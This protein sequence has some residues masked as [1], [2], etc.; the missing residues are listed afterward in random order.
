MGIPQQSSLKLEFVNQL[1]SSM[2]FE[3]MVNIPFLFWG[4]FDRNLIYY[5]FFCTI[6]R[7]FYELF[8]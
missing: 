8:L 2:S 4:V 7:E 3:S 1:S 6:I 5:Y